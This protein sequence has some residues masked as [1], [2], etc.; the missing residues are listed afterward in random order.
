MDFFLS[1]IS[2]ELF[3]SNL[4]QTA[5]LTY[6][7]CCPIWWQATDEFIESPKS[8]EVPGLNGMQSPPVV[9]IASESTLSPSGDLEW[10]CR[11]LSKGKTSNAGQFYQKQPH[12]RPEGSELWLNGHS[13]LQDAPLARKFRP[14]QKELGTITIPKGDLTDGQPMGGP[15]PFARLSSAFYWIG[16]ASFPRSVV[17]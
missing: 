12:R 2:S 16:S 3:Y 17:G 6:R 9:K 4:K 13:T 10:D 8:T 14:D 1:V 11:L 7:V 5:R 15:V